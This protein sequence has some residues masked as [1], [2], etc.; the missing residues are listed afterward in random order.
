MRLRVRL[1]CEG[2]GHQTTI[3]HASQCSSSSIGICLVLGKAEPA[4][5]PSGTIL[6]D[7]L[8]GQTAGRD[9]SCFMPHLQNA[10]AQHRRCINTHAHY[11]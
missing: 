5:C 10:H 6:H 4:I 9:R 11:L 2:S 3:G 1:Y 8:N 7:A